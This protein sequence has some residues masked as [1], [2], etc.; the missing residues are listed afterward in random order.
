[1]IPFLIPSLFFGWS[2]GAN[3]AANI[4]GTAVTSKI[5]KYRTAVLISAAFI[6]LGALLQGQKGM[7]TISSVSS[8]TLMTGSISVLAAA[9]TM[10]L[11]TFLKFPVSSSQAIIGSIIAISLMNGETV[12]WDVIFKVV[13][14]WVLTPLGGL[15]FGY[16]SFKILA[17]PFSKLNSVY[18]QDRVLKTATVIIGS[19]GAYSLGAN[20]VANITGV[21]AENIGV[22]YATLIGGVSIAIGVL[23]FS[24]RVMFTIG[25]SIIPLDHFASAIAVLGESITVWIY[26]I[27]GIPVST[28]QAIV[29]AVIGA[30]IARGGNTTDKKTVMK[31]ILAWVNTPISAALISIVICLVL[32]SLGINI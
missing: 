3:D 23:T 21:F 30:G 5:I 15:F 19:Y 29:G 22:F 11:M 6:L 16:L 14:A 2:L 7:E 26:A 9:I 31:I 25:K 32:K 13:L 28:S 18:L 17:K 24:K 27:I 1:M 20:N 8:Q 12:N 4:F 10:T